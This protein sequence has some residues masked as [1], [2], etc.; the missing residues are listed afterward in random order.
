MKPSATH[1]LLAVALGGWLTAAP[2]LAELEILLPLGRQAYQTNE[3]ID[4]AIVRSGAAAL[5]AGDLKLSILGQSG[6]QAVAE[7]P[8][9]AVAAVG[10]DARDTVHLHLSGWLL[11]PDKY[12]VEVAADGATASTQLDLH[13]HIRQSSFKLIQWGSRAAKAEQGVL[14]EESLGLNLIYSSY[15]GLEPDELIRT[16]ADYMWCCTMSGAHQMDI[17]MEC[18]WSDPYVLRGG[19]ARVVRRAMQRPNQAQRDRGALLRRAGTHL[20]EARRNRR[21][22]AVQHSLAGPGL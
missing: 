7:F 5:P 6:S 17:R 10:P 18:D 20:V 9:P 14:G 19:T 4:L 22:G 8:L 21:H 3:R 2:A 11:R 12:T 13:S 15:G 16:G 1:L